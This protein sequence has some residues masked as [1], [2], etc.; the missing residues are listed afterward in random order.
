MFPNCREYSRGRSCLLSGRENSYCLR[1]S[2]IQ[3]N[4]DHCSVMSG[5]DN[6]EN[7]ENVFTGY[8][9]RVLSDSCF[10]G[11]YC[12]SSLSSLLTSRPFQFQLSSPSSSSLQI[13]WSTSPATTT[14]TTIRNDLNKQLRS[15]FSLEKEAGV[16]SIL[17]IVFCLDYHY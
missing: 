9:A 6:Q 14:T 3:T 12:L 10:S 13:P 17:E 16:K 8:Q 4:V 2:L 15:Q 7:W 11:T 1:L 5:L